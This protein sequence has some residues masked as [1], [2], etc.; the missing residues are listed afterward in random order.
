MTA[1]TAATRRAGRWLQTPGRLLALFLLLLLFLFVALPLLKIGGDT[2]D[3]DGL[4]AWGDVLFSPL[5][6]NLFYEPLVNTLVIGLAVAAL[7]VPIGG[8]LAWLVM[9]TDM[10]GRGAIGFLALLPTMIPSFATALAWESL[11]RN[12]RLGGSLGF[13][14]SLGVSVPDWLAWGLL[15]TIMALALNTFALVFA[16]TAAALASLNAELVEAAN[17]TGAST[18]RILFGIVL[19]IVTPAL[20]AGASLSFAEGVSSFAAPALLGLPVGT[21]TLSTRIFGMLKTG[22]ADRGYVLALLLILVAGVFV[23]AGNR[24]LAGRRS[25][26][27]ITGKGGRARRGALGSWRW[28]AAILAFG[29]CALGT[30]VPLAVLALASL[31]RR[32]GDLAG[33]LTLHYWAGD[34]DPAVA[35]GQPGVLQNDMLMQAAGTTVWLGLIAALGAGAVGL[36]IAYVL[37]RFRR[38]RLTVLLDQLSF[39]PLL[40]PAV[41]FGAAYIAL[42]GAPI[43][44]LPALYGT[45]GLLALALAAAHLPFAVQS[46]R[47]VVGQVSPD[48][49]DGARIAGASLPRRFWAIIMPLTARGLVAGWLLVFV[50]VVREF[51][52]VVILFTPA[53]PVL[54]VLAF[55]YASEGFAQFA[56]TITLLILSISIAV[57]LLAQWLQGRHGRFGVVT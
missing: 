47:A 3:R 36:A 39:L 17:L 45:F 33:G 49:E 55:R 44:P 13:L 4:A 22:A 48:L 1:A 42:F 27:T 57:T 16:L 34:S 26:V 11:F 7:A 40:V 56:H 51:A 19:P 8:C 23:Y 14:E 25:F 12:A 50:N 43:G 5:S 54:S 31:T 30:V 29:V 9:Q 46:G 37:A 53:V 10:P 35:Q 6:P 21:Q 2:L 20:V 38:G 18:R 15:P 52:L 28:P 32:S 24:M 41:A